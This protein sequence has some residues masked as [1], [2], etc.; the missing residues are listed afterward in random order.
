[1]RGWRATFGPDGA[2]GRARSPEWIMSTSRVYQLDLGGKLL[3]AGL[4]L[5]ISSYS[6]IQVRALTQDPKQGGASESAAS[7]DTAPGAD[8]R[9]G[10][11]NRN[12]GLDPMTVVWLVPQ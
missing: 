3:L 4:L 9:G 10:H 8:P 5:L 2:D 1:M 6:S 12:R 7:P 11:Q